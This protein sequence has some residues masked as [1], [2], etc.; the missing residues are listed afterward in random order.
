VPLRGRDH[1]TADHPIDTL[2]LDRWSPRAMSGEPLSH[3]ELMSLFEAARWAP[4]AGNTQPWRILYAHRD[5]EQWPVF[6]GLLVER[7]QA[8]CRNAAVLLVFVS[9]TV[10]EQTGRPLKTHSYDTGA[11][12]E[13]L[14]LQSILRGLVVHGMAG[15]DYTR[16]RT[17]LAIPDEFKV[18]AMAAIGRPGPIDVLPPDFQARE[19]PSS[20]RPIAELVFNGP[21]ADPSRS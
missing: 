7:N 13:N 3:D 12:W 19:T 4:S 1:R 2:F 8:W 20:R 10:N 21:Y 11:A 14:A 17:E 18:E 15:F 16:A 6:F 5:S 9:R